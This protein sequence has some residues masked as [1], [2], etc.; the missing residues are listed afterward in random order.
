MRFDLKS[1]YINTDSYLKNSLQTTMEMTYAI[2]VPEIK[3]KEKIL[4]TVWD[5][6]FPSKI[7]QR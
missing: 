3:N 7:G 4:R 5:M 6:G 1:R 2:K